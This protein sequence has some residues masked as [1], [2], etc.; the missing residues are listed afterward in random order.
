MKNFRI[1]GFQN[2]NGDQLS[3]FDTQVKK[4]DRIDQLQDTLSNRFGKKIISRAESLD[5]KNHYE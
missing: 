3:L 1:S 5:R 2:E 4:H